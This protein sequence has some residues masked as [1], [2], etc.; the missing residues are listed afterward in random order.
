MA[1]EYNYPGVGLVI[2]SAL[3]LLFNSILRSPQSSEYA[4]VKLVA[5]SWKSQNI[6]MPP[7]G[8]VSAQMIAYEKL[9]AA[10]PVQFKT[11]HRMLTDSAKQATDERAVKTREEAKRKDLEAKAQAVM[12]EERKTREAQAAKDAQREAENAAVRAKDAAKTLQIAAERQARLDDVTMKAIMYTITVGDK[13][14][15]VTG[16]ILDRAMAKILAVSPSIAATIKA[17][18][19][20]AGVKIDDPVGARMFTI[21]K[22]NP[23]YMTNMLS[24]VEQVHADDQK[25]IELAAAAIKVKE[26]MAKQAASTA[27]YNKKMADTDAANLAEIE[28]LRA[29]TVS[30]QSP[31]ATPVPRVVPVPAPVVAVVTAPA[32]VP[33]SQPTEDG[34]LTKIIKFI[35]VDNIDYSLSFVSA[36][37]TTYITERI[38]K[39]FIFHPMRWGGLNWTPP[40]FITNLIVTIIISVILLIVMSVFINS[41]A[42]LRLCAS[43]FKLGNLKLFSK[44]S[45]INL[46]MYAFSYGSVLLFPQLKM[47]FMI[48]TSDPVLARGIYIGFTMLFVNFFTTSTISSAV[49]NAPS[50]EFGVSSNASSPEYEIPA[51]IQA[52]IDQEYEVGVNDTPGTSAPASAK[53][54]SVVTKLS[55]AATTVTNGVSD[56]FKSLTS[57]I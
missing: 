35:F 19:T 8:N 7:N 23:V 14:V 48:F 17:A 53:S 30:R 1:N 32:V 5:D 11:I 52:Q 47:P 27:A 4:V 20:S 29:T 28:R 49:C 12:E 36:I 6:A 15:P 13:N 9:R 54:T 25:A 31:I 3:D 10:N 41:V 56:A 26:A 51:N 37:A 24:Y 22:M 39:P 21:S 50:S 45:A 55:D 34:F 16:P 38:I 44:Y 33:T 43:K 40:S 46:I 57:W 18:W 42:N 2:P